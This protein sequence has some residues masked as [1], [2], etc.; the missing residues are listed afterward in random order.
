[1]DL[2]Y[3]IAYASDETIEVKV[4]A[5]CLIEDYLGLS[6]CRVGLGA[7]GVERIPWDQMQLIYFCFS[8]MNYRLG[9]IVRLYWEI[10]MHQ[11]RVS[12]EAL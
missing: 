6:N 11:N 4:Q 12:S 5:I 2:H 3:G 1:M 7:L 10:S 8:G 9:C